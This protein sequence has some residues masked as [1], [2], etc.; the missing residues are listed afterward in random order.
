MTFLLDPLLVLI[1]LLS[2]TMLGSSRLAWCVRVNAAQGM[3]LGVLTLLVTE[4]GIGIRLVLFALVT[5]L[6]RGVV[7]PWLLLRAI[8]SVDVRREVHP[9]VGYGASLLS[10]IV[11]VALSFWIASQLVLPWPVVSPL[12]LPLALATILTGL[13][14]I[15]GR[16]TAL[17]Q[18]VGYLVLEN[19]IFIFGIALARQQPLLVEMGVLLDVFVAVFVMGIMIFHI[20]R[21]FDHIDVDQLSALKD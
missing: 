20:S 7:F 14:L 13:F 2:L 5:F 21:E 6:L 16:R 1:A 10:G 9:I 18:V 11:M 4:H 3:L 19:G 12:V 15:V 17:M 8:R